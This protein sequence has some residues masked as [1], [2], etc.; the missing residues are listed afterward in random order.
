LVFA[1]PCIWTFAPALIAGSLWPKR[2]A[3]QVTIVVDSLDDLP[4][5]QAG[6]GVCAD[7]L[8][9]CTLRAAITEANASTADNVILFAVS[10]T[11]FC[12]EPC[13]KLPMPCRLVG[14]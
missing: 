8:G 2:A 3:G 12:R 10:G 6:D 11:V 14:F 13:Q 5:A 9:R 1:L 4:D 7:D